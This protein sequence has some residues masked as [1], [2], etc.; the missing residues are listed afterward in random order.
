MTFDV[1]FILFDQ[2]TKIV[3]FS[4]AQKDN[5]PIFG[6]EDEWLIGLKRLIHDGKTMKTYP[7]IGKSFKARVVRSSML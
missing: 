1:K 7:N 4:I 2:V 6:F 3:D 5:G